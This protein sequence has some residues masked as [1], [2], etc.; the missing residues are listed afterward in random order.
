M[1]TKT[2]T[3]FLLSALIVAGTFWALKKE[4]GR[5]RNSAIP[6]ANS[7]EIIIKTHSLL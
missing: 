4:Y 1:K 7:Q 3:I 5:F 6:T 2:I